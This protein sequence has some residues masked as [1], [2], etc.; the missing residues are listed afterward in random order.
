MT[1]LD[2]R[3]AATIVETALSA[4]FD[5]SVVSRLREDSP[6][7]TVGMR[8]ADAVCLADAISAAATNGGHQCEL[9]DSDFADV[10]TV[11]DLVGAVEA[12]AV[13]GSAR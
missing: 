6:M 7:S 1:S 8:P 12:A 11:A 10:T 2:H 4:V 3:T 13:E 5:A 9:R